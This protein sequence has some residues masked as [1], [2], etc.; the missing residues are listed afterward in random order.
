[1]RPN[2][3]SSDLVRIG[4]CVGFGSYQ[5]DDGRRKRLGDTVTASAVADRRTKTRTGPSD[6][7]LAEGATGSLSPDASA[8]TVTLVFENMIVDIQAC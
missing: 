7:T 3:F 6:S 8:R 1:M 5:P 4:L 2:V